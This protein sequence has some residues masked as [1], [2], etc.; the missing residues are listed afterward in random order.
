[1]L[2][3]QRN[4]KG[5]IHAAG[6]KIIKNFMIFSSPLARCSRHWQA[7]A[8]MTMEQLR[9]QEKCLL[10]GP[11][12]TPF[13]AADGTF[14]T[15]TT[16]RGRC[17]RRHTQGRESRDI[18]RFARRI[19]RGA[20]PTVATSAGKHVAHRATDISGRFFLPSFPAVASSVGRLPTFTEAATTQAIHPAEDGSCHWTYKG[21]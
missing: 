11:P 19:S 12:M 20:T 17:E 6:I 14:F 21:S 16:P 15:S 10:K 3:P 7:G 9:G 5:T 13:C 18:H 1:M 2:F 4:K 8:V